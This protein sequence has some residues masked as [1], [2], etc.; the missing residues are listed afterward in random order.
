MEERGYAVHNAHKRE[1][2][3][4]EF[5]TSE[6]CTEIDFVEI[7]KC[8][9]FIAFPGKPASPGTHIEIGWASALKKR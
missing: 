5:M 1:K 3:G 4:R 7:D 6:Q 9:L 2:W 8:D